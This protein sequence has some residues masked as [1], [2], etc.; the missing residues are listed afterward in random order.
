[1]SKYISKFSGSEVDAYISK[2]INGEVV[3]ENTIN[4]VEEN[5]LNP[6]ASDTLYNIFKEI[7]ENFK[8]VNKNIDVFEKQIEE[9]I[10]GNVGSLSDIIGV[11]DNGDVFIKPDG[12]NP[13]N[14]YTRGTIS[15]GGSTDNDTEPKII[16][17]LSDLL[18]VYL[19]DTTNGQ[20][21][22]YE[23]GY[24]VNKE[25]KTGLTDE[26]INNM[27]N[28]INTKITNLENKVNPLEARIAFFENIIGVDEITGDVYIKKNGDLPR[29]F[30]NH[31][32]ISFGGSFINEDVS[33]V[34]K[35][36]DLSDV[37]INNISANQILVW[38]TTILNESGSYGAWVNKD[39]EQG[40]NTEELSIYLKN[41]EYVQKTY[42]DDRITDL[43]NGAPAA[44]D[45]LKEIADVLSSNVN[46]IGDIMLTLSK[47]ADKGTTLADYGI[48][49]ALD[50]TTKYALA[51]S[52]GG[53][54]LN[55]LKLGGQG[56]LYYATAVALTEVS[57][58]VK[59]LEDVIGIDKNGDVYIKD[60]NGNPR[61]FYTYGTISFNGL[62]IES[63]DYPSTG[64]ITISINGEEFTSTNG[65]VELPPYPTALKN[66][67]ALT[68]NGTTYDGSEAVNITIETGISSV[69]WNDVLNKP[70]FS[71]VATSGQYSDLSGTPSSLPASDVYAW[72]KAA[73]KPSYAFSEITGKPTTLAGYGITDA[74]STSGGTINGN[75]SINRGGY[76]YIS[77]SNISTFY[78]YLGFSN[79]GIPSMYDGTAWRDIIHSGNYSSYALPLS[80]GTIKGTSAN[81]F[82]ID[83]TDGNPVVE[84]RYNGSLMGRLGFDTSGNAIGVVGGSQ[85]SLIHSGN[86]GSYAQDLNGSN[87]RPKLLTS[88]VNLDDYGYG[89]YSYANANNPANSY[90]HNAAM[91]AFRSYRQNDTWQVAFDGNGINNTYG[92]R[93]GIRGNFANQGWTQWFTLAT[94]GS[95]VASATKL[96]TGRYLWGNYFNGESDVNGSI[97]KCN[98][99]RYY[100][101][102][103]TSGYIIGR[104]E[105]ITGNDGLALWTYGNT[106]IVM[107][108]GSAERMRITK[109]GNVLIGTT[110]DNRHKLQVVGGDIYTSSYMH[111]LAYKTNDSYGLWKGSTFTSALSANDIV[112]YGKIIHC[113]GNVLIGTTTDNSAYKLQVA[114]STG[115]GIDIRSSTTYGGINISQANGYRWFI[116]VDNTKNFYLTTGSSHKIDINENGFVGINKTKP[117]RPLDIKRD[118][119]SDGD[120]VSLV[121]SAG[122]CNIVYQSA[123]SKI[124][125]VGANQDT[126]YWWNSQKSGTVAYIDNAGNLAVTGT[127][128]FG[129]DI[130][131]KD[132]IE[133]TTI[134]LETIANAP[135]FNYK[136]NDRDDKKIHLGTSAQYWYETAF[137][138]AV[139][140]TTDEKLWTMGYAEI[141]LGNTITLAKELI[142]I[143]KEVNKIKVLEERVKKLENILIDNNIIFD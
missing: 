143:K 20:S 34:N 111:S 89:Y 4:K 96:Q 24:W 54:A 62:N 8:S 10:K 104:N 110:S 95:N 13:R 107:G 127:V 83:R 130:R 79:V 114:T 105:E 63:G 92:P 78:G 129:S 41:N 128:V 33:V 131:Y 80:G 74:L 133:N 106:P 124:W 117:T 35:I 100:I 68:I 42:V 3:L 139:V 61:N 49:D 73:T 123:I 6:V 76:P 32:T 125:S 22:V 75:L 112:L 141:A 29:N 136:W 119:T 116:G 102:S 56:P 40:L 28:P 103:S 84:F 53:N 21:L 2:I 60:N 99:V 46:S 44:Y 25:I 23:N 115:G 37:F 15:F 132:I 65:Y 47:K 135:L 88:G 120:V 140:P 137:K 93:I 108:A 67:Y 51:D 26:E 14:F 91:F 58:R 57:N 39:L 98:W 122:W 69:T 94:L 85:V 71:T 59:T 45:T 70:N 27:L 101:N 16:A 52:V 43:I 9:I 81:L 87:A 118:S 30:Y 134:D 138:N 12:D 77:Y 48:T 113:D 31:G 142:P 109:D 38:D 66:P 86:I 97:D 5:K 50:N 126:F 55:A 72:A 82:G 1:M 7:N 11:D 121:S 64:N 19:K 17:N 36:S 18:D 90:G